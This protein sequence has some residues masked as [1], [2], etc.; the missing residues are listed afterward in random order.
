MSD[1]KPKVRILCIDDNPSIHQDYRKVLCTT[2]PPAAL[3]S[4]EAALFDE[5]QPDQPGA[6]ME[7]EIDSALQGAEGVEKLKAALASSQSYPLAFVDMR[8]PPG[9]D[10]VQTIRELWKVDKRLHV[11]ICTAYSDYSADQIASGLGVSDQ[12]LILRK[13][14]EAAEIRQLAHTLCAKWRSRYER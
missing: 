6:P 13:P 2:A 7:F 8:M 10:G 14:F 9:W 12:M 5:A 1:A 4:L 3:K 11:V